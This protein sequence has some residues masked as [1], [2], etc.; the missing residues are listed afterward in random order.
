MMTYRK[1]TEKQKTY[2]TFTFVRDPVS[3]LESAY[4]TMLNRAKKDCVHYEHFAGNTTDQLCADM[5]HSPDGF[6]KFVQYIFEHGSGFDEHVRPQVSFFDSGKR[7][8]VKPDLVANIRD[9]GKVWPL[10]SQKLSFDPPLDDVPRMRQ[11][12]GG[13]IVA[14]KK[15]NLTFSADMVDKTKHV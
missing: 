13:H 11:R 10:I 14:Q 8:F 2:F 5:Y 1:L 12:E 9:I 3:R 4:T 7:I 15:I 6:K